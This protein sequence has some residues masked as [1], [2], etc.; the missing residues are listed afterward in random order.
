MDS[1][2]VGLLLQRQVVSLFLSLLSAG[3]TAS[4]I[5]PDRVAESK[6]VPV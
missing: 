4:L 6:S 3:S 2:P 1:T 5:R